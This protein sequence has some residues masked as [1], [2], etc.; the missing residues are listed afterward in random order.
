M[1][2]AGHAILGAGALMT[3]LFLWLSLRALRKK[4]LLQNLPTSKVQGVFI[5]LVE[6]KGTAQ[7]ESPLVSTLAGRRCVLY[8]FSVDEHWSRT[9]TETY[10]DAQGNSRTRTR[11][12]SGWSTVASG[13]EMIRFY[14]E[15]ET[16]AVLVDPRKAKTDTVEMFEQYCTPADPLYYAKGPDHA[17]M[18]SDHR[19]RFVENGLPL[20]QHLYIVGKARERE[21]VVAPMI[22][23]DPDAAMFL[24]STRSEASVTK[25]Y[26]W[27]AWL[28]GILVPI[29]AAAAF[30][31]LDAY[32]QR[33]PEENVAAYVLAGIG[34]LAAWALGWIWMVYNGL[35]NLRQRVHQAWSLVDVQLKRRHVL[36]PRL[37]EV[38]KGLRDHERTVQTEVAEL[39][40][41]LDATAPGEAGPDPRACVATSRMII[42]RYPELKTNESFMKLQD[43]LV[44]TEQRIALAR[45]YF[46]TIATQYNTRIQ[47]FPDLLISKLLGLKKPVQIRFEDGRSG[48]AL[49][50]LIDVGTGEVTFQGTSPLR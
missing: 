7:A 28:W 35:A 30:F 18:D 36:I 6:L 16:G 29:F 45:G 27:Q 38:V 5:G 9:V 26:G 49:I 10:T 13:G 48:E 2:D 34:S 50:T 40:S 24:I 20:R 47:V 4:R 31:A 1:V 17:V 21:D 44:E 32:H 39:R 3:L 8:D 46:N 42:E 22:A 37:V 19:R 41:Q 33:Q 12:E 25:G 11:H 43:Q 15:D 23:H 14:L